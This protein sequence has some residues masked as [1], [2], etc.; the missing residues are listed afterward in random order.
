MTAPRRGAALITVLWLTAALGLI[1]FAV[2]RTVNEETRRAENHV[3]GSRAALLARGAIERVLYFFRVP[4][5]LVPGQIPVFDL[6]VPR[7]VWELPGGRVLVELLSE[8]GKWN[9]NAATPDEL[10]RVLLACGHPPERVRLLTAAILDWRTPSRGPTPF[11]AYYLSLSPTFRPLRSSFQ[12]IEELLLV[13]GVTPAIYYGGMERLAG[14]AV[15]ERPGLRDVFSVYGT[16]RLFDANSAHPAVLAAAGLGA[17]DADV[18]L[19]LRRLAPITDE[20]L[21]GLTLSVG[22][23]RNFLSSGTAQAFTIR[24]TAWPRRSDG[25]VSDYRRSSAV[26][27]VYE[28]S[29]SN[30][31]RWN[32]KQ[33]YATVAPGEL[34]RQ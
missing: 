14:G 15:V 26:L 25:G 6:R 22:P 16:T 33:F 5:P 19:R 28:Q 27:A 11:D 29:F 3:D 7:Y 20:A 4:P 13:Q 18:I 9:I 32:V 10:S 2:A 23:A 24:A 17:G 30:F 34:T 8:G 31:Y 1:S 21:G 12:K